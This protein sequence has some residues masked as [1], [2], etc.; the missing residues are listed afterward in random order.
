MMWKPVFSVVLVIFL[1]VSMFLLVYGA[2]YLVVYKTIDWCQSV[3]EKL[4][5]V[6]E[7]QRVR[8]KPGFDE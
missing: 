1:T 6:P 5:G 4:K 7:E 8:N 2:A 3:I